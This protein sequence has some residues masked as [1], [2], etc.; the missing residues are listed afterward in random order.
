[1]FEKQSAKFETTTLHAVPIGERKS[2]LDISFIQA[3]VY[4]CVPS[5]LLGGLLVQYMSLSN[6]II[7]GII[8]Y[9]I[10]AGITALVGIIGKD[11][12]MPTCA[13]AMSSFG[14][15][16]SRLLVSS[17]FAIAMIGWFTV[18]NGLCGEAFT[19]MLNS[20]GIDIPNTISVIIWGVVMLTTAVYGINGLKRL[21]QVSV[22][23]L[24]AIM[25][26]GCYLA[27]KHYGTASL[28][29]DSE[30]VM[31]I[32][33]GVV[34]TASFLS[35]GMAC[36]PD[37]TRYQRSR[38]GVVTSS[39]LG[40]V[41]P[42]V[43]MLMMGALLTKLA[44]QND[45]TMVLTEIG[46]PI[47][48]MII[49]ILA[50]WTT[51]TTNA[52]SAGID[53]VMLFN[54]KDNKRALTTLIAGIIGTILAAFGFDSYFETFIN[55]LGILFLPVAGVMIADYWIYRKGDASKWAY[56]KGFSWS[57]IIAWIAGALATLYVPVG[58]ALFLGFFVS[59]IAYIVLKY[60]LPKSHEVI[61]V[62]EQSGEQSA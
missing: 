1:M 12:G 51:N 16:G 4:I 39:F 49:L 48:G 61:E 23:A 26:I 50:T 2:W 62:E 32:L 46:L 47:L 37:F 31:T 54:L 38:G 40:I 53:F 57:G 27:I 60:I 15:T 13:V 21:N 9:L 52:Y 43:I 11:I 58:W 44:G 22:P 42:G 20:M 56:A 36:A 29:V 34:L 8:G 10:S 3:G 55:W 18:Q 59:I 35:V 30:N 17:I 33:D 41:I 25:V 28:S 14:K 6:A 24:L 7:A 19:S 5:L 45:L